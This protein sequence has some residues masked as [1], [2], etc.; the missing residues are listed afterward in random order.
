[1]EGSRL[2]PPKRCEGACAGKEGRCVR[3]YRHG[4]APSGT[5]LASTDS[6]TGRPTKRKENYRK[7]IDHQKWHPPDP[8][9]IGGSS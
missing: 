2:W 8:E 9:K 5:V 1:M 6:L 7:V 3:N 4:F